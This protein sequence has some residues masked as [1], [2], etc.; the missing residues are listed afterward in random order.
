[1]P[2]ESLHP[3]GGVPSSIESCQTVPERALLFL[4]R[5]LLQRRDQLLEVLALAQRGKGG[6]RLHV[7]RVLVAGLYS[8]VHQLHRA[9][10]GI[11]LPRIVGDSPAAV[12]D[13]QKQHRPTV[14]RHGAM[15]R[16]KRGN[17][18]VVP[19]HAFADPSTLEERISVI[20]ITPSKSN[21]IGGHGREVGGKL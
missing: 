15:D 9:I 7:C 20:A 12:A 11:F 13:A 6:V 4:H 18:L 3:T 10:F 14:V 5:V 16:G 8:F 19:T 2:K 17:G 1:K 21:L